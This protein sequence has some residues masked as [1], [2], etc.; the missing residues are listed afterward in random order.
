M[1]GRIYHTPLDQKRIDEKIRKLEDRGIIVDQFNFSNKDVFLIR[2]FEENL[3][4]E[5]EKI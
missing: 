5:L 1:S 2:K 3:D 4:K